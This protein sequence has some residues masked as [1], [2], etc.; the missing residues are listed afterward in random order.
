CAA[1]HAAIP[2]RPGPVARS[3]PSMLWQVAHWPTP[4]NTVRPRS[5]AR[6]GSSVP[7]GVGGLAATAVWVVW[8]KDGLHPAS[9]KQVKR[10]NANA[11]PFP[12][13]T[14]HGLFNVLNSRCI[15]DQANRNHDERDEC[16]QW[17]G[18]KPTPVDPAGNAAHRA[19]AARPYRHNIVGHGVMVE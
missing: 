6:A 18:D 4:L 11:L 7:A 16:Q 15:G 2:F 12:L 3:L 10:K 8:M 1:T 14:F 9:N 19:F 13:S 17:N 5:G